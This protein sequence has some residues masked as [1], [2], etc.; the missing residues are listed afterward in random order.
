[1]SDANVNHAPRP[2]EAEE[3]NHV[4]ISGYHDGYGERGDGQIC[5]PRCRIF[6]NTVVQLLILRYEF[7]RELGKDFLSPNFETYLVKQ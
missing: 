3:Y 2:R 4:L 1:M 6:L 7:G 5:S